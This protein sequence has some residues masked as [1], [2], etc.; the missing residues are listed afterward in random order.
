MQ[1]ALFSD[2]DL[3]QGLRA[4]RER[5]RE[6]IAKL[7]A[8]IVL[9]HP[10]DVLRDEIVEEFGDEE[11]VFLFEE[12]YA[13]PPEDVDIDASYKP[14]YAG[15]STVPGTRIQVRV[16]FRGNANLLQMRASSYSLNP[17]RGQVLSGQV[18]ATDIEHHM[19]DAGT[20][21]A[22]IE[23]FKQQLEQHA[24]WINN[25]IRQSNTK[26]LQEVAAALEARRAKL[27]RDRD[28][29]AALPIPIRPRGDRGPMPAPV[30]RKA[31]RLIDQ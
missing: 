27:L 28:L 7:P 26:M 2:Y 13:T 16:P 25:D 21:K 15:G 11:L 12:A 4:E 14:I 3:V 10:L 20:V 19:L 31:T 18:V 30:S 1:P 17:P 22:E 9:T 6:K 8:D 24:G 5:A 23:R 29:L